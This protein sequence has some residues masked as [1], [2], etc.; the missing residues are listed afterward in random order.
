MIV[1]TSNRGPRS[2][3]VAS[4]R[5]QVAIAARRGNHEQADVLRR[6]LRL[7]TIL[8]RLRSEVDEFGSLTAEERSVFLDAI[9]A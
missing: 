3:V 2:A 8:D 4:L 5:G 6:Q 9:T 7:E 1:K